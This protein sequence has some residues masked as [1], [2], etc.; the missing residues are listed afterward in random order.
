MPQ[1]GLAPGLRAGPEALPQTIFRQETSPDNIDESFTDGGGN[2]S[3][4]AAARSS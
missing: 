4:K 2:T 3:V 1:S